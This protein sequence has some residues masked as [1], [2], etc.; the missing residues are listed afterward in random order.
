[1][2]PLTSDRELATLSGRPCGIQPREVDVRPF[3]LDTSPVDLQYIERMRQFS[4]LAWDAYEQV[5]SLA[6][7]HSGSDER[8]HA[9]RSAD[10]ALTS[11]HDSWNR[12][13]GWSKEPHGLIIRLRKLWKSAEGWEY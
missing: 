1:V 8:A 11:W 12:D 13:S 7:K 3:P 10:E 2:D 6:W 9:L 4:Y 5:Y